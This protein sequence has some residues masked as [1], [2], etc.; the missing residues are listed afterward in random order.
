MKITNFIMITILSVAFVACGGEDDKE[1]GS[2]KKKKKEKS[3]WKIEDKDS[4]LGDCIAGS[5]HDSILMACDCALDVAE[6]NFNSYKGMMEWM[7]I[8]FGED[9]VELFPDE[10]ANPGMEDAKAWQYNFI[11]EKPGLYPFTLLYHDFLGGSSSLTA[12]GGSA[13][14]LEWLNVAPIGMRLLI[15]DDDGR[16]IPSYIPPNTITEVKPAEM[17]LSM[18]DGKVIVTWNEAG[19]LQESEKVTGPWKD[20]VDAGSPYTIAPHSKANFYRVRH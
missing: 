15:N 2:K 14:S 11:V 7:N 20:V 19:F 9:A 3:G 12:S 6:D 1:K 4:Y 5:G 16:A 18:Q 17:S 13:S 8:G 10:S